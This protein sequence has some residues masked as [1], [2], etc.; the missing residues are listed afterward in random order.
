MGLEILGIPQ[1]ADEFA[2]SLHQHKANVPGRSLDVPIVFFV[3]EE[4]AKPLHVGQGLQDHVH[5][6]VGLN[7]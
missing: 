2:K 5:V 3:Q 1:L 7:E 6:V 4:V